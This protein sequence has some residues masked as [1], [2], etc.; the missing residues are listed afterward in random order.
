VAGTVS[1]RA[2]LPHLTRAG[3]ASAYQL[4]D[5]AMD[6]GRPLLTLRRTL[7]DSSWTGAD[8]LGRLHR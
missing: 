1:R 2:D 4:R 6:P 3:Y 7:V 8:L 5:D